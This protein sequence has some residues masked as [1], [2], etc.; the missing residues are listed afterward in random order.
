MAVSED[1]QHPRF[2]R[3]TLFVIII[4]SITAF[5]CP[6][7]YY[8]LNNLGA[9]GGTNPTI[10]NAANAIIFGVIAVSSPFI[11]AIVNRI[12]PRLGL[13]IGSAF[14]T[15]Y[16]GA[17][18]CADKFHTTW[19]LLFAAVLLGLSGAFL[20][21]SSAAILLGYCEE[22]RKGLAMSVKFAMQNLGGC[23]GAAV[24]LGLNID[25]NYNGG[26]SRGT[27]IVFMLL[28]ALGPIFGA[29][30][31]ASKHV[32][33]RDSKPVVVK[34]QPNIFREFVTLKLLLKAPAVLALIPLMIY[35]Q[36]VLSY[37]WQ[38]NY[39]YFTVRARALNSFV[40]YFL[41]LISSLGIGQ[42]L[43]TPLLD[44]RNR[45]KV[46]FIISTLFGAAAWILAE[47]TQMRY[48]KTRPSLDFVDERYGLG[49]ATFALWGCSDALTTTYLFWLV[50]TLTND[51]NESALLG[52]IVGS[53]GCVGSA[54]AFVVTVEN[55]HLE[56]ACSINLALF[57]LSVP[58][59]F[60][61]SFTQISSKTE[62][63]MTV[64]S[65]EGGPVQK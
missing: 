18:Y 46:G 15:P 48:S 2:F 31:P 12:N 58:S 19:F 26:V 14:Y 51:V 32:R 30:L 9:G 63:L 24:S 17:L 27:Y 40:F 34:K 61:V 5:T 38:F 54:L 10:V 57:F 29:M 62:G 55:F 36:W 47:V 39:A 23:V 45:A 1:D 28:M 43:D 22:D 21:I 60:W 41:G 25:R 50:G 37:Q 7:L 53:T 65:E 16:A 56:G 42:V 20:W 49:A 35:V 4:V 64:N 11:G 8:A 13:L 52:S 44:R 3:S 6:G 59:L 33:R